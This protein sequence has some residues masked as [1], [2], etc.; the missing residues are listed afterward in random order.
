LSVIS[1]GE[2]RKVTTATNIRSQIQSNGIPAVGPR[3]KVRML[4]KDRRQPVLMQVGLWESLEVYEERDLVSE[5]DV[6]RAVQDKLAERNR[7]GERTYNLNDVRLVY[8][9]GEYNGGPDLLAPEY[10]VEVEYRDLRYA[11][12][13]PTWDPRQAICLPIVRCY[14]LP[15]RCCATDAEQ[16]LVSYQ[17]DSGFGSHSAGNKTCV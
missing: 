5:N 9:A 8:F 4:F 6:A 17:Q 2:R 10:L 11:G 15:D 14:R 7:C 16:L 1:A 3:G 12:R 13:E